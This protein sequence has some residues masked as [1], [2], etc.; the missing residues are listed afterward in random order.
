MVRGASVV[1]PERVAALDVL[2]DDGRIAALAAPGSLEHFLTERYCLYTTG[3]A[4]RLCRAEIHHGL[5]P[6][7]PA[8]A[9]IGLTTIAPLDLDGDPVCHFARSQ[10]VVVWPLEPLA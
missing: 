7:Q 3:K 6:L 4:G 8:E 2:C 10:D 5:W 9:E 1:L